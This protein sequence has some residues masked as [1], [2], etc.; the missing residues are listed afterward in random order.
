MDAIQAAVLL[1]KLP[2][3]KAWNERRRA[4]A[5]RY[6]E[7]LSETALSGRLTLPPE[8]PG[9]RHVYHQYVVRVPDRDG[10]RERMAARGS[11]PRSSIPFRS[12]GRNAS[13][14]SDTGKAPSPRRK[15]AA[16]EVLALP[17]F[18][19]LTNDEVDRVAES[20]IVS[21]A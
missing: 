19:E 2:Y 4:I 17:I 20:L 10:V 1:A 9:R 6:E 7:R 16:K 11:R 5:A 8:A 12:T 14:I 13:R 15:R 18:A 21:L 3:L